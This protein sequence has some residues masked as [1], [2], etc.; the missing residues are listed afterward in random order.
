MF[1]FRTTAAVMAGTAL[2]GTPLVLLSAGTAH[3]DVDRVFHCQGAKVDVDLDKDGGRHEIDV[4]LDRAAPHSRWKVVLRHNGTVFHKRVHR[5]DRDGEFDV[6]RS[7]ADKRGRDTFKVSI[8]RVGS[9]KACT[10]RL[11]QR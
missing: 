9:A 11:G 2:L 4:D 7:R 1:K 8:K 10:V 3:A 6:E 5:A